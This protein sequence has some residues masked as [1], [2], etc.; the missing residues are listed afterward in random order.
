MSA[1]NHLNGIVDYNATPMAPPGI[2]VLIYETPTQRR[3]WAQHGV[4]G[5]YIGYAP[6]HYRNFRCYVPAT[7][8]ERTAA[9]VSFFPHDFAVPSNS[10]KDDVARA[11]RD[12]TA[13]LK[14]SYSYTPLQSI[15]DD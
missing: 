8:G 4:E 7:R 6:L 13:A 1:F 14:H 9:T 15:G 11:I 5:W 10:H 2:K 3:T 12:L